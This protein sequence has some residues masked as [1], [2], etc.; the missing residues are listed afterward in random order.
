LQKNVNLNKSA[1][2]DKARS[3]VN[4]KNKAV[5]SVEFSRTIDLSMVSKLLEP[6]R[7]S[8]RE[9][10]GIAIKIIVKEIRINVSEKL[11]KGNPIVSELFFKKLSKLFINVLYFII[12]PN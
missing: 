1:M 10:S 12:N 3:A 11:S 2:D 6:K 9:S 5:I 8:V 7:L 4:N